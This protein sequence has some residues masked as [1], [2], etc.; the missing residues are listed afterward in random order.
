MNSNSSGVILVLF[1]AF[2]PSFLFARNDK[3]PIT[4]Y[5]PVS[6]WTYYEASS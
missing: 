6:K 3:F 2:I 5:W 1:F 4:S